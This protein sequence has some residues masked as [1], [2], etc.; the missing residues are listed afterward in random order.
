MNLNRTHS[1]LKS[2]TREHELY[3][4]ID[5]YMNLPKETNILS[6]SLDRFNLNAGV[7]IYKVLHQK[8]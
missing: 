6:Y 2:V 3:I 8:T 1:F 4:H 7:D 5:V